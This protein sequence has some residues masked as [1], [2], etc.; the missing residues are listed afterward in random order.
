MRENHLDVT[1]EKKKRKSACGF[2]SFI[3]C[4]VRKTLSPSLKNYDAI[5]GWNFLQASG[6]LVDCGRS[7]LTLDDAEVAPKKEFAKPLRLC[8]MTDYEIP[9][10]SIIK[11]SVQNPGSE[12]TVDTIV[13][14]SKPLAFKKEIF[15]P[16]ILVTLSCGKTAIWVVNG[17]ST[18]K[19]GPQD[20]C[21]AHAEPFYPDSIA[22]ISE[23][24]S[25]V[26]KFA[27]GKQS[28]EFSQMIYLTLMMIRNEDF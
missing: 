26:T 4:G 15:L 20:M 7:Q 2:R 12:D 1:V 5:L 3:V 21:V 11:I 19:V 13:N 23:A 16:A 14:G 22:V 27:E 8:A 18:A 6:S 28:T 10:Y 9:A 17:Q 24:S 25:P